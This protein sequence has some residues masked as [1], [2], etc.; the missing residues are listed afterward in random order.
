MQIKKTLTSLL[1]LGMAALVFYSGAG[2]TIFSYCCNDCRS[3]GVEAILSDK[4]CEIHQH[5]H[6]HKHTC[7]DNNACDHTAHAPSSDKVVPQQ[8]FHACQE[9]ASDNCCNMERID[10]DWNTQNTAEL[11]IDLSPVVLDLP[12][13]DA[14]AE[15]SFLIP[16]IQKTYTV[17][18]NGP[19][20]DTP[21]DYLSVLTVLLI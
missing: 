18:P 8:A 3:A 4:C 14:I 15:A 21:R 12:Y 10:Y 20:L 2:V 1:A 19:P 7:G 6:A 9:H 16:I 5:Q 11:E 17:L 13:H